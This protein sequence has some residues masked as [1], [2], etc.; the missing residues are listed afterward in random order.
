[1]ME[2]YQSG[3][4][5]SGTFEDGVERGL[6]GIL[7]DPE[8]VFRTEGPPSRL[9]AGQG[10]RINDLELASRLAFFLWSTS[11]DDQLIDLASRGGLA[12][13]KVLEAQVRRMLADP[14]SREFVEN[15]AGQWLQ[16]RNLP[17]A[18]PSTQLFPDFDDNL[19]QAFRVEAEMFFDSI[20]RDDRSVL[21]LLTA[22][23]TFVNERLARHYGIPNIYGSR[24][25]RVTLSGPLEAR[26]GLLGK[27]A[28]LLTTSNPDRTSP[29]LR[30]KWVLMNLLGVVPPEPPPNV[31]M[32]RQSDKMANG[33]PVPLEIS[34][35]ER[36]TEHR[37]SPTCSSCHQMMDPIGFAMESFDAVGKA[38]THEFGKELDLSAQLADGATFQGPTGLRQALA[39]YSPQFVNNLTEKLFVYALGR[40]VDHRDMPQIRAIVRSATGTNYRLSSLIL[41]IVKSPAFT[42]NPH[43]AGSETATADRD[44]KEPAAQNKDRI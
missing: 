30:G 6:Q 37:A 32:L 31:P 14:K 44:R 2:F 25:R 28:V 16:L 12:D 41:G 36:M 13:P 39:R 10:Y 5:K 38:R 4:G 8:F 18:A 23:Y 9:N 3:R 17:S 40:S 15:F 24:F 29:V 19:R 11:P 33:Q 22:D 21:D 27:G 1:L 35:R 7:S 43:V 34:M 20:L 42:M 26:R